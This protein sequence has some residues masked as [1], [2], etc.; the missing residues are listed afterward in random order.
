MKVCII[1]LFAQLTFSQ[2]TKV[3]LFRRPVVSEVS[4]DAAPSA[5]KRPVRPSVHRVAPEGAGNL[6][7]QY[8]QNGRERVRISEIH[9]ILPVVVRKTD[10]AALPFG[11]L[12]EAEVSE[13]LIAF[14]DS[15]VPVR[16]RVLR[17]RLKGAVFLGEASLEKNSKRI[18]V[19]FKK[20]RMAGSEARYQ[21]AAVALDVDGILGVRGEHHSGEARYFTAEFIAAAAAGYADA[22]VERSVTPFG[23]IQEPA[24]AGNASKKAAAT[25]LNRTADR[26]AEKV[27]QAPEFTELRGPVPIQI[28]IQEQPFSQ[29]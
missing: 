6:P 7:A 25:A 13:G 14:P 19:D 8:S 3:N 11:E 27:R 23:Q 15:K 4:A 28:L 18:T 20:F 9:S 17:G 5:Q 26:L 2:G 16:A 22:L 12:V 1:M 10:F 24:T 21:L 29:D